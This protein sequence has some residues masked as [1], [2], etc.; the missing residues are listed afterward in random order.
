MGTTG[1][2][3][4]TT[5]TNAGNHSISPSGAAAAGST[6]APSA[7]VITPTSCC[8]NTTVFH[9]ETPPREK[10]SYFATTAAAASA[11]A[12][13]SAA[14]L[15]SLPLPPTWRRLRDNNIIHA[16]QPPP[17]LLRESLA[18]GQAGGSAVS[19]SETVANFRL[20]LNATAAG[21]EMS[22]PA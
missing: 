14:E 20:W 9:S 21:G 7:E 12:S 15:H 5:T 11:P 4:S 6:Q 1:T 22:V 16:P 8:S 13:A 10:N 3:I 18:L 17:N 19:N 2:T